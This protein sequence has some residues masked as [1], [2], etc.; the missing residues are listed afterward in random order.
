[1]GYA[2]AA[3][4]L[5]F[6]LEVL[7]QDIW[8]R[9]QR[10]RRV[11][12]LQKSYGVGIDVEVKAATPMMGGVVFMVVALAACLVRRD[13][14][15]LFFWSLPAGCGL[16]GFMD[17]R[18]KFVNRSSEGFSSLRKLAA[19]TVV[20]L[21]WSLWAF[22][23]KGLFL[24]PGLDCPPWAAVSLTVLAVIGMMN[25]VNIT[26][27]LDGLA[28]GAFMISLVVLG[29][30]AARP[31]FDFSFFAVLFGM[32]GGFLLCN[33]HPAL[34][35]MGDTGSHFLGGAL[36]ALAIQGGILL[37]LAAAGFIFGLELLSSALQILAIR[38]F[39]KKI[40]RMAPLH[41]HFQLMGWDETTVTLRFLVCHALG[42]AFLAGLIVMASNWLGK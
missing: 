12:Q 19:Q 32:I 17:D 22:Y 4:V 41:H 30:L 24:W 3:G 13:S 18:L 16:I 26:D 29:N 34:T 15:S 20:A 27:G 1:M 8:I 10:K 2:V 5:S 14:E 7:L 36:V 42:S 21:L 40:F 37:G 33:V 28:G 35:F 38:K 11:T 39:K 23:R 31:G 25:A 9:V 6:L